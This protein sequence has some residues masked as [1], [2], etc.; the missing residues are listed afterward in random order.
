M[1]QYQTYCA[2]AIEQDFVG[3]TLRRLHGHSEIF[4]KAVPAAKPLS[5]ETLH[6]LRIMGF[7]PSDKNFSSDA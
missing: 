2:L 3:S 6:S 7:Y 5:L 1:A 4:P